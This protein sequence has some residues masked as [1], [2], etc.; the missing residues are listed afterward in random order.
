MKATDVRCRGCGLAVTYW[1][2]AGV[3]IH[4]ES[5]LRKCANSQHEAEPTADA[6]NEGEGADADAKV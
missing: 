4:R 6:K 3:W 2:N 1:K 5:L